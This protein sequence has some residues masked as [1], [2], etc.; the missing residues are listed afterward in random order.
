LTR[1]LYPSSSSIHESRNIIH[2]LQDLPTFVLA[3][4]V[5]KAYYHN[6][7]DVSWDIWLGS[8]VE[9]SKTRTN[10]YEALLYKINILFQ[11]LLKI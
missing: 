1:K 3:L 4:G 8:G 10:I 7:V 9:E 5:A 2:T 6:T 11:I